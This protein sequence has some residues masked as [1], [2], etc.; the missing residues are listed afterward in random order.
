MNEDEILTASDHGSSLAAAG[1]IRELADRIALL[2][3]A[4][5]TCLTKSPDVHMHDASCRYREIMEIADAVE[6]EADRARA[7]TFHAAAK[8]H[9]DQAAAFLRNSLW[10]ERGEPMP[11]LAQWH[12][13]AAEAMLRMARELDEPR[14]LSAAEKPCFEGVT[15]ESPERSG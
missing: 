5:C 2:G 6:S 15:K 10:Y 4:S 11:A 7:E 8:W 3:V 1:K 13:D 14:G 12:R 9:E